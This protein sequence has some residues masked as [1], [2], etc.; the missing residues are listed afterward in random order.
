MKRHKTKT[1]MVTIVCMHDV[2]QNIVNRT[3]DAKEKMRRKKRRQQERKQCA[4]IVRGVL[5]SSRDA[6]NKNEKEG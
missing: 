1:D 4:D 2:E 5:V 6:R 3:Y